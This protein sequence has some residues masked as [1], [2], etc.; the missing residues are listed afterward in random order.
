MKYT[1]INNNPRNFKV[2]Y[3]IDGKEQQAQLQG[4]TTR[5][6]SLIPGNTWVRIAKHQNATRNAYGTIYGAGA[7]ITQHRMTE[8]ELFQDSLVD[9]LSQQKK[10]AGEL[11]EAFYNNGQEMTVEL[12]ELILI[13]QP[14]PTKKKTKK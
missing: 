12:L 3:E 11:L 9:P 1:V 5:Y 8:E 13:P 10:V 6:G 2:I 14:Q 7:E 4:D